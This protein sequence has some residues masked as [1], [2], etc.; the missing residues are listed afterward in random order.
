MRVQ[1]N[2]RNRAYQFQAGADEKI[3][4]A[5]L[6]QEIDLPYECASGTCGTCKARLIGG[7]IVDGWPQ[8][9]G[10]KYLK[11]E[12]GEFLMCQ[13]SAAGDADIEVASYVYELDAEIAAPRSL[14]GVIRSA[15][16]LTHD[17][18]ALRIGIEERID[19]V[20]GQFMLIEA[21]DV[22]GRR[23]YSMVNHGTQLDTLDFIVK[24]KPGGG[25]SAWL[26]DTSRT[27]ARVR[28][29]GPLGHATFTPNIDKDLLCIAGG[30]GIAGMM[31]ILACGCESGYFARRR[32]GVF[33]GVRTMSD[34]FYLEELEQLRNRFP[35][36]LNITIALSDEDVPDGARARH[37]G[38]LFERGMVHEVAGRNIRGKPQNVRAYVAG[39]PPAVEAAIR[40]LLLQAKLTTNNIRYDKFS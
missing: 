29:C 35:E 22:P 19:F 15:G 4:F 13:C 31:A 24:R 33:F 12:A 11:P 38:L 21:P 34:T 36:Q 1:A 27:G 39:P 20:P 5:G 9:P 18:M 26:F 32:G 7:K 30:T 10:R 6:R 2:A 28:L 23:G 8:A 16:L 37:P 25:L 3:L 40:M 14:D 17:V